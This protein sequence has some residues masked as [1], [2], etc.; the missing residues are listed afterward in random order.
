MRYEFTPNGKIKLEGKD[1][2]RKRLGRSPDRGD[3][4]AL[5]V[6]ADDDT[7]DDTELDGE[8]LENANDDLYERNMLNDSCWSG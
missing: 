3:A 6:G 8:G 1:E 4:V 2:T 7:W 5:A